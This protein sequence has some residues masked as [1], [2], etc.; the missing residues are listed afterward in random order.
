[1]QLREVGAGHNCRF[2]DISRDTFSEA[3][4]KRRFRALATEATRREQ[5][6][7]AYLAAPSA[8]GSRALAMAGVGV[9]KQ[10]RPAGLY[11]PWKQV[12]GRL[13]SDAL[14]RR[15]QGWRAGVQVPSSPM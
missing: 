8:A 6:P 2:R 4:V 14:C 15:L 5:T 11:R 7:V 13:V 1:M 10:A 12:A 3:A 9:M